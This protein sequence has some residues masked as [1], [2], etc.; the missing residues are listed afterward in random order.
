[1]RW[2]D[3]VFAA[4]PLARPRSSYRA[5]DGLSAREAE[6]EVLRTE[7]FHRYY[8]RLAG[9]F[10]STFLQGVCDGPEC[11]SAS[12][13]LRASATRL[14]SSYAPRLSFVDHFHRPRHNPPDRSDL[15]SLAVPGTLSYIR[16]FRRCSFK[17]MAGGFNVESEHFA[18][19]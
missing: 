12:A 8:R 14:A 10:V 16:T 4:G 5:P 18:S 6:A 7:G 3:D 17:R 19:S 2:F 15:H 13:E 9:G 11:Y 1:M